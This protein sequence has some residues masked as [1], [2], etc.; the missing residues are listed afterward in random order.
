MGFLLFIHWKLS[1]LRDKS[2]FCLQNFVSAP[3]SATLAE[4]SDCQ[5]SVLRAATANGSVLF[6]RHNKPTAVG[7]GTSQRPVCQARQPTALVHYPH[8]LSMR[9][10]RSRRLAAGIRVH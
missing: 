3:W 2:T 9:H 4:A 7:V 1:R 10:P 6:L 5:D 8:A